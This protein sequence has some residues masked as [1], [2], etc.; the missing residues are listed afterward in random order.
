M[1]ITREFCPGDRY[2]Y[3]FGLCSY[4]NGT[5]QVNTAQDAS[6][7]GTWANPMRLMIFSY[8]EGDM[9]LKEAT[10]PYIGLRSI[11]FRACG[12]EE[13]V[14]FFVPEYFADVSDGLPKL[15]VCSG[16][17]LSEQGLDPGECHPDG[18]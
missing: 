7:F 5:A 12:F 2:V 9:T 16:C 1:K 13:V 4:E 11:G 17:G 18:V 10:L 15:I 3:D 14:A 6:N 8:C